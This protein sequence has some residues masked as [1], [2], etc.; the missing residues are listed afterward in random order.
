MDCARGERWQKTREFCIPD[1]IQ[2]GR[3]EDTIFFKL[4]RLVSEKM[5]VRTQQ[6]LE[7][8]GAKCMGMV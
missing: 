4:K 1:G 5:V 2:N 3:I 7:Q 6:R 8:V